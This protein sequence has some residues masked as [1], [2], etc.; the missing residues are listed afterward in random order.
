[1]ENNLASNPMAFP[2]GFAK[3]RY[4]Q[5]EETCIGLAAT[6]AVERTYINTGLAS[7]QKLLLRSLGRSNMLNT[8]FHVL[9]DSK[10][11]E[12]SY[13]TGQNPQPQHVPG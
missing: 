1:M 13:E 6:V 12:E 4:T 5:D 8:V 2:V 11:L 3:S 10:A 9:T 7:C